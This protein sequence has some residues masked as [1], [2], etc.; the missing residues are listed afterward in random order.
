MTTES[1]F[2]V[3]CLD[4]GGMRGVYQSAYLNTFASRLA[5]LNNISEALDVGTAFDLIVGTSTG[6][7]VGCALAAGVPL[8][9]VRDLYYKEGK[10]IFPFQAVRHFPILGDILI[11]GLGIGLA[12]GNHALKDALTNAFKEQTVGD[13]YSE[14]K[15]ALAIPT[16]DINRHS[17]VVFKTQHLSRSNGRDNSRTLAD[18]CL[19]TSAAPMLRSM[20]KLVEPSGT[21][22]S[23][24]AVYVDG[25]LWANNPGALGMIEAS[26]ILHDRGETSRP[27]HLFMLGSLP[28]QGGEEISDRKLNRT[29]L[30]WKVGIKAIEASLNAQAVGYDYIAMKIASLR[31]DGSFAYRMPAQCP[32]N[33]LRNYLKNLDDARDKA[34]NA[35]ERQAIS[36][37]DWAWS[38][39]NS[40]NPTNY[41]QSFRDA[42]LTTLN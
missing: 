9:D 41:M 39:M 36:D 29:S 38:Q 33:E 37:V 20:A 30:G 17:S 28:S 7:I 21:S 40:N 12:K 19:A 5:S 14:R 23:T 13:I 25:G 11:R 32:S 26:E 10:K 6:G 8:K 3:L 18:I 35:L 24:T 34:L 31:N 1:P 22:S 2:R 27:I 15:I 16:L 4:G 42:L